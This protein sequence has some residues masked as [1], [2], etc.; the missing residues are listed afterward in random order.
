ME[1]KAYFCTA[2]HRSYLTKR[3]TDSNYWN[4]I[5]M[6]VTKLFLSAATIALLGA[7]L[8]SC[9][10]NEQEITLPDYQ[11]A[12]ATEVTATV[13]FEAGS[14]RVKTSGIN[15]DVLKY[16]RQTHGDGITFEMWN[17]FNENATRAALKP[18]LDAS[19]VSFTTPTPY[20]IAF[21]LLNEGKNPVTP[22]RLHKKHRAPGCGRQSE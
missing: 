3:L 18:T 7:S 16:L 17:Y 9:S 6:K 20:Y 11:P 1:E 8:V 2:F 4:I 14:I 13:E 19:T 15:A 21:A 12:K 5:F 10:E 22:P